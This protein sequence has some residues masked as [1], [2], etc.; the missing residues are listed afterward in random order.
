MPIYVELPCKPIVRQ[1]IINRY[2]EPVCFPSNDW[3]K[4][5]MINY[6]ERPL[7]FYDATVSPTHYKCKVMLP[8][9]LHIYERHGNV[10]SNTAMMILNER[11]QDDVDE[12]I[13]L[14][15]NIHYREKGMLL[16][17]AIQLFRNTY[18]FPE[19][20][21]STDAITKFYYRSRKKREKITAQTV[22]S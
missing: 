3:L 11:V 9:N 8:I 19:E 22:L 6:L 1:Y 18:N 2:G 16:S 4:I 17:E 14:F 5:L 20:A 12:M 21:Y 10:L 13:Y 15:L 7:K